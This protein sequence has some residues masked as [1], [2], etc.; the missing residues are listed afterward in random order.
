M[1]ELKKKCNVDECTIER[2]FY[3]GYC[4]SHHYKLKKYGNP[5]IVLTCSVDKCEKPY[6]TAGFCWTHYKR[7]YNHG[8]PNIYK[9]GSQE[10]KNKISNSVKNQ[11]KKGSFDKAKSEG[12]MGFAGKLFASKQISFINNVSKKD[13]E[14]S[15]RFVVNGRGRPSEIGK[16]YLCFKTSSSIYH[17][18]NISQ[19]YHK[20]INDF[21]VLCPSCHYNFDLNIKKLILNDKFKQH[22]L[23]V[24]CGIDHSGKTTLIQSI[25]NELKGNVL[26]ASYEASW[27][28]FK[29]HLKFL[30]AAKS[31][32]Q[33]QD[34]IFDRW[35]ISEVMY[36]RAFRGSSRYDDYN[37]DSLMLNLLE[38]YQIKN[39]KFIMCEPHI[40]DFEKDKS[41]GEMFSS[42]E[43]VLKEYNDYMSTTK[44]PWIM[45]DYKVQGV[46][47]KDFV[48]EIIK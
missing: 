47:I 22:T 44:L 34:V 12:R 42:M 4:Q 29:Y 6:S 41:R 45:Y 43:P 13:Y 48:E 10:W 36:G 3:S 40:D 14:D 31:L 2:V 30:D 24:V 21:M 28:I 33:Y 32:L 19:R 38:G 46:N 18:A 15:H 27:N 17:W 26:H 37:I 39:F 11:W 1:F 20:D 23:Y 25:N 5:S 8:D 35:M 16:C 9:L 7:N